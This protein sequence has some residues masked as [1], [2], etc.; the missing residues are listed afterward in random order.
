MRIYFALCVA[1]A[2]AKDHRSQF[3]IQ[4][5]RYSP[6]WAVGQLSLSVSSSPCLPHCRLRLVFLPL[7]SRALSRL[8]VAHLWR[9]GFAGAASASG[10]P[11]HPPSPQPANTAPSGPRSHCHC[12]VR[13][14]FPLGLR[15][16]PQP[17]GRLAMP[18]CRPLETSRTQ[19]RTQ[20]PQTPREWGGLRP[21]A[22]RRLL[23]IG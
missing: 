1:A 12:W 20:S 8:G 14:L 4:T 3:T 2:R 5:L 18:S 13:C 11:L 7:S 21:P 23:R 19:R 16:A 15:Q 6:Q 17:A 9:R 22:P 10:S